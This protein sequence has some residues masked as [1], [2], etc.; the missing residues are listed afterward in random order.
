MNLTALSKDELEAGAIAACAD[1]RNSI[2]RLLA[3]LGEIE[4]RRVH[5]EAACPSMFDYCVRKLRMS[6]PSASRKTNLAR[7]VR[8]FPQILP[9]IERSEIHLSTLA[10]VREYLTKENC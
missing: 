1:E 2:A 4:E 8:R 3:H 5:L 7:L 9:R 10:L 6:E